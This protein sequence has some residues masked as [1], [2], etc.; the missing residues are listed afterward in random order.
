MS[1]LEQ[2]I[3][4]EDGL[5][6]N[7]VSVPSILYTPK[8]VNSTWCVCRLRK[9]NIVL[10]CF[11]FFFFLRAASFYWTDKVEGR[12]EK[13]LANFGISDGPFNVSPRSNRATERCE[14]A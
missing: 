11:V 4:P 13:Y 1:F 3:S 5:N 6:Y 7:S 8:C 9:Y 14:D 12:M 2:F 10:T